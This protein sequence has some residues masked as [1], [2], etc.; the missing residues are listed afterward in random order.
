MDAA[1]PSPVTTCVLKEVLCSP[2]STCATTCKANNWDSKERAG[3][4]LS[5]TS[6]G[7]LQSERKEVERE[8]GLVCQKVGLVTGTSDVDVGWRSR[9]AGAF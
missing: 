9:V 4:S 3:R 8:K 7:S 6:G 2:L 5:P 1:S